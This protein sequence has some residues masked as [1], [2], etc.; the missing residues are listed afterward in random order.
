MQTQSACQ[1]VGTPA[2]LR[3]QSHVDPAVHVIDDDGSFRTSMLRLLR[4]SGFD[5]RGYGC[6][7]EFLLSAESEP[8]GCILLDITMPGPS[9]I[10]LLRALRARNSCPP[11]VFITGRDDV[12]TSVDLMKDGALDYIVKPPTAEKVI[13]VVTHAMELDAAQRSNRAA[14]SALSSRFSTLTSAERTIFF[15]ILRNRLN[16]QLAVDLGTCERTIKAQRARMMQKLNARSV[17]E[18]V[19]LAK[20]LENAPEAFIS[21]TRA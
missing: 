15:G 5:A 19:R 1:T 10:D 17:P 8:C 16:K 21:E 11:V 13:A 9:G 18:L 2:A 12:L 3:R 4:I 7:G 6:A 14:F 20:L